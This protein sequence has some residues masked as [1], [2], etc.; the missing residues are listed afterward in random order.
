MRLTPMRFQ[1]PIILLGHS[2]HDHYGHVRRLWE[3]FTYYGRSRGIALVDRADLFLQTTTS[4]QQELEIV[5]VDDLFDPVQIA[6]AIKTRI[7]GSEKHS[8]IC[9]ED[10]IT[11]SYLKALELIGY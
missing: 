1:E 2:S 7:G 8:F 10:N 4:S 9:A 3:C 11:L 5:Q 6:E